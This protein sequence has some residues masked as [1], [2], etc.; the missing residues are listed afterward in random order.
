[1]RFESLRMLFVMTAKL[2]LKINQLD[3]F[4]AYLQRKLEEKIYMSIFENMLI[5]DKDKI[6]LLKK[7]LYDLKQFDRI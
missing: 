3:I 7:D 2:D 6:L 5:N 1:M 4:N